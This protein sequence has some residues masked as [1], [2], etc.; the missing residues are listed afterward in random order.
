M[1]YTFGPDAEPAV[2]IGPAWLCA[3]LQYNDAGDHVEIVSTKLVTEVHPVLPTQPFTNW[4][5]NHYCKVLSPAKVVEWVYVD[6]LRAKI[7]LKAPHFDWRNAP[8]A[9]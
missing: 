4:A 3:S 9:A 5:G 8:K 6:S 7:A 1:Q 2:Q